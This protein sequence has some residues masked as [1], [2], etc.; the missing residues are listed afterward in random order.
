MKL[1]QPVK[2]M[3]LL[4]LTLLVCAI[5]IEVFFR[6]Y[7]PYKSVYVSDDELNY[8]L[9]PNFE[10]VYKSPEGQHRFWTNGEGFVNQDPKREKRQGTKRIFIVGDSFVEGLYT[11]KKNHF[12]E[13]LQNKLDSYASRQPSTKYEVISYGTSSWGTDN[14]YKY[15][16]TQAF[17]YNPD[18]VVL[19]YYQNDLGNVAVSRLFRVENGS[20]VPTDVGG[21][22]VGNKVKKLITK[23]SFYSSFCSYFQIHAT[24]FKFLHPIMARLGFSVATGEAATTDF[25][26]HPY[27]TELAPGDKR[28]IEDAW[29]KTELLIRTA[30]TEAEQRGAKFALAYI[31]SR[32]EVDEEAYEGFLQAANLSRDKTNMRAV[33]ERIAGIS[34]RNGI[35]L[36]DPTDKFLD[37]EGKNIT[38]YQS[39]VHFTKE[40]D[41]L[42]AE[43]LYQGLTNY[44]MIEGKSE[45]ESQNIKTG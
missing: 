13:L 42:F 11:E 22:T 45:D 4:A 28:T 8:K 15:I 12:T 14:A 5:V 7:W 36:I 43:E 34:A 26:K 25:N 24:Q 6:F 1:K 32:W 20:V 33:R 44:S 3:L 39:F 23:C 19:T 21:T 29:N 9:K 30:K 10:G 18:I 37:Y 2:K 17:G 41:K 38:L 40:G 16:I 27:A 35:M 31:P